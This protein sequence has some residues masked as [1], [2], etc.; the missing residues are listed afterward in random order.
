MEF[1]QPIG[2]Y[3]EDMSTIDDEWKAQWSRHLEENESLECK[4]KL[5]QYLEESCEKMGY[6]FENLSWWKTNNNKF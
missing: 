5:D 4:S 3:L 6:N 1:D 2:D